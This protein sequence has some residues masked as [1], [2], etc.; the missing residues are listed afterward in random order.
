MSLFASPSCT[1]TNNGISLVWCFRHIRETVHRVPFSTLNPMNFAFFYLNNLA[2][3]LIFTYWLVL[4]DTRHAISKLE[5]THWWLISPKE[6]QK[7]MHVSGGINLVNKRLFVSY[8]CSRKLIFCI[9]KGD[10]SSNRY[11]QCIF[12]KHCCVSCKTSEVG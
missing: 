9:N 11:V 10:Q 8:F 2:T 1:C 6:K 3:L 4:I 5:W 12:E 7:W